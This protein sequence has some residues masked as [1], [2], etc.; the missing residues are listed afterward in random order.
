M[1]NDYKAINAEVLGAAVEPLSAWY[2]ENQKALPWRENKDP[3]RIWLSEIM[4]QQTR[5]TAVIPYY[6]RFMEQLPDVEALARVDDG[7]LM[8]LWEGL[9]YYSR[10]RNLKKA[11]IQIVEE[12]GGQLPADYRALLALPG[13]GEYTAGAIGSIAFGLPEP[14]VDGNVLRV[15]TR[16]LCSDLDISLPDT[17]KQVTEALR[18]I[19][20]SGEA[21][22]TLTQAIM[23]LGENVCIPNGRPRCIDC[24]LSPLCLALANNRVDELPRKSP[25]KARRIEPK[26]VFLAEYDGAYVIRRR[27][28]KGLLAGLWE[29]PCAEGHLSEKKAKEW[30]MANHLSP[31][32]ITP[33]GTAI[34]IFTHKEWHMIGYRVT[35]SSPPEGH[36]TASPEALRNDYAIPK[37]FEFFKQHIGI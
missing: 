34:H 12:H 11:A 17:K 20:P 16:L 2:S 18:S 31:V 13:I 14:A 6:H 32:D 26:T 29:F 5:T 4:L 24:P 21:A 15:V 25:K 37:A 33:C 1:K 19:Y 28:D 3:Y 8:K 36:V 27:P 22:S 10:A 35:L 7:V 30:L 23:E 9:G